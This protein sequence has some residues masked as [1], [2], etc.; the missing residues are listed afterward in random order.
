MRVRFVQLD[1]V[2]SAQTQEAQAVKQM[3]TDLKQKNSELLTLR[4]EMARRDATISSLMEREALINAEMA[5]LK[6]MTERKGGDRGGDDIDL[7]VLQLAFY[8]VF[9]IIN[10]IYCTL[11]PSDERTLHKV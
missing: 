3:E 5:T 2:K 6:Q 10:L 9:L 4:S 1:K 7:K 8:F 11:G